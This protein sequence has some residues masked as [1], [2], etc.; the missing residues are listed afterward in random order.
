MDYGL[1]HLGLPL[2]E[3]V[4][5]SSL[6]GLLSDQLLSQSLDLILHIFLQLSLCFVKL[7]SDLAIKGLNLTHHPLFFFG[8]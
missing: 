7:L 6:Q 1:L 3:A 5:K 4:L 2:F 8:Y